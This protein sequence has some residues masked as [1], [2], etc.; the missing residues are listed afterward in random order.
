MTDLESDVPAA[1]TVPKTEYNDHG[2]S[3]GSREEDDKD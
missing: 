2:G 1:E 3:C